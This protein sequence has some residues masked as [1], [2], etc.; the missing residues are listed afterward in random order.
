MKKRI[1]LLISLVV[2]TLFS[3]AQYTQ[4]LRG[5]VVDHVLQKPIVGATV[6]ISSHQSVITDEAGNF[7][8]RDLAIGTYKL[9]ITHAGFKEISL[10][11]IVINSG[12]ETVLT[13]P[14]EALVRTEDEVVLK[15]NTRKN[16]P[17]NDMSAVSTRAFT[18]EETQKY[19]A[20]VNDPLRMAVA[21]P[22]VMAVDDG[23]NNIIIRG[24]SPAGLL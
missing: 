13:I 15:S 19:A 14:L 21:F 16:K 9:V 8:F 6:T 23:G 5:I 7:R 18:V 12:K 22:G 2:L 17:L 4:Q 10:D 24:N 1:P 20:A 11:N 3:K